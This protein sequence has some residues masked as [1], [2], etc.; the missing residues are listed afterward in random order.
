[1][2]MT[3]V[4]MD[5]RRTGAQKHL[6][7]PHLT[8]GAVLRALPRGT[9]GGRALWRVDRD[10]PRRPVL[11][12]LTTNRPDYSRLVEVAGYPNSDAA[13][14]TE[15]Y[16]KL[17]DSLATGQAYF[18]RLT[19]NPTYWTAPAPTGP[20]DGPYSKP[21]R[22]QRRP[23]TTAEHQLR[24]L[25]D[26]A[27]KIGVTVPPGVNGKPDLVLVE[28]RFHQFT[29]SYEAHPNE[30][31]TITLT[32]ATYHGQ[33]RVEDPV[34]LRIALTLGVGGAKIFGCG[35]LTLAPTSRGRRTPAGLPLRSADR[36]LP[37]ASI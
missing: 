13:V 7:N 9:S 31:R 30:R 36:E 28:S 34:A 5:P 1:V 27:G 29:K 6:T 16:Q 15:P 8:H 19:A 35:L 33:L 3:H 17:L 26:R 11:V 32:T 37:R 23:H 4:A 18:F 21:G 10:D 25:L 22:S 20:H 2:Y 24:W 14:T 12:S